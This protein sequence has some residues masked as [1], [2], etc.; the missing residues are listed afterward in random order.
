MGNPT[1][2]IL[3]PR[4]IELKASDI[5]G[6]LNSVYFYV[7]DAEGKEIPSQLTADSLIIFTADVAPGEARVYYVIP[8]DTAREYAPVA[9]GQEYPKRRDDI[10]YENDLVGFRI[11]GPGTQQAGEK[12]FGYDI[13]FKHPT[14][15]LI[16]PQLYAPETSDSVWAM[17]DSLRAIDNQMAEDFIKTFSYHID[18]GLGMDCYAVGSTL[19]DGVAALADADSIY[20]PWCYETAEIIENGPVRFTLELDFAPRVIGGVPVTEHRLITLDAGQHLNST[21]VW[22]DGLQAPME[23]V[24]GFPLRDDTAPTWSVEEG[25]LAYSDPTQGPD[26]GRA[27]LGLTYDA[28]NVAAVNRDGHT[29]VAIPFQ[30]SDTLEYKWGFAWDR[31][32]IPTMDDWT[33][34]LANS[35]KT[36]KVSI[37]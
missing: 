19:G 16:V 26:N 27:L 36:Y 32:D 5:L 24:T 25:F 7:A 21:K 34:Y 20:Y 10:A 1:A 17:V 4:T 9:W 22:Y 28:K 18:H 29:L 23:I 33:T 14:E 13:F 11:Y 6:R 8:S 2:D 30:L 12:A 35:S 31:A 3:G 37:K 15:E